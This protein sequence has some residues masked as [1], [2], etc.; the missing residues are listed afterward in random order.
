MPKRTDSEWA[1]WAAEH[2]AAFETAALHEV[3]KGAKVQVGFTLSLYAAFPVDKPP[4]PEREEAVR[5]LREELRALLE[6]AA[7]AG[8]RLARAELETPHKAVMRP[9]NESEPEISLEWRIVHADD[10][11][12]PVTDDDRAGLARLEKRLSGM[13]VKSGHW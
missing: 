6:D 4:G 1:A 12:K 7:P 13:G 8:E 10:Y 3:N 2:R 11:W 5:R 9:A